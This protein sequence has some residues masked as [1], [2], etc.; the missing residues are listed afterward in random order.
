MKRSLAFT[1]LCEMGAESNSITKYSRQN[2]DL[3]RVY[4]PKDVGPAH[5]FLD[6]LKADE[7]TLHEVLEQITIQSSVKRNI[8]CLEF[9]SDD[10]YH[11]CLEK[12]KDITED[13]H[14]QRVRP[15][16]FYFERMDLEKRLCEGTTR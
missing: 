6:E 12:P 8:G 14:H 15:F 10:S 2:D 16:P 4:V 11:Y 5:A 13:K 3:D 7:Q 9:T 1:C